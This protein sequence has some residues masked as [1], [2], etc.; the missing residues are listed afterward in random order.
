MNY[1]F[2]LNKSWINHR[3]EPVFVTDMM[4]IYTGN[5]EEDEEELEQESC[6]GLTFAITGELEMFGN[7]DELA[8]LIEELGGKVVG[9]VTRKTDYLINNDA[10]SDS[11]KNKKAKELGI[12]LLTEE[13]FALR[14]GGFNASFGEPDE[15]NDEE[16]WD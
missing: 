6:E 15:D 14:F 2:I 10:D 8:E 16:D 1:S 13:E 3:P 5:A 12:P 11:S 7:R 4:E 9:S